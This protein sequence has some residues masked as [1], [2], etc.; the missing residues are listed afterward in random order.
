[1]VHEGYLVNDLYEHS[2]TQKHQR[3][4]MATDSDLRVKFNDITGI[5]SINVY[6]ILRN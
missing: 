1:M 4:K 3:V 2:L 6:E 5:A